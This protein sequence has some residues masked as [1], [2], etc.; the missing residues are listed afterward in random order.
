[1]VKTTSIPRYRH[2]ADQLR[3][4][5]ESG[6][7]CVG[8]RLPSEP[9]LCRQYGIS[10]GTAV[11]GVE[12]I[13]AEGLAVRRQGAGTFVA[14]VSLKREPG[15]LLSF[16]DT[17]AAQGRTATQELVS[18]APATS[19][20]STSLGVFEP[21]TTLTRLR[22]VDGITTSLHISVIPDVIIEAFPDPLRQ[23]MSKPGVT[24]FSLYAAFDAAGYKIAR[25]TEQVTTRLAH[26]SEIKLLCLV[27]PSSVMVV[28]RHTYDSTERLIEATEAIYQS[29]HYSYDI[30]LVRSNVH[31]MPFKLH[32]IK[33]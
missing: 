21:S 9:E 7:Y 2:L 16:S 27:D 29:G 22:M 32:N 31:Q 8:E 6:R 19:E 11:K 10:R 14:G 23:Q 4:D 13:V 28:T 30:K 26:P 12:L 24:E 15:R 18:L 25:A 17:I 3:H 33:P 1:M 20:C 5:I